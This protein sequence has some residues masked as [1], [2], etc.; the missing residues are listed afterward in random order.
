MIFFHM[1]STKN[2][3]GRKDSPKKRAYPGKAVQKP[4][5]KVAF[6][7]AR[8][9]ENNVRVRGVQLSCKQC[10]WW[11]GEL[12]NRSRA[13]AVDSVEKHE[14]STPERGRLPR[15]NENILGK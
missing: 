1:C 5:A 11:C 8:R 4:L 13:P 3:F 12:S 10:R 14:K 9:S 7:C 2:A 6:R 15:I